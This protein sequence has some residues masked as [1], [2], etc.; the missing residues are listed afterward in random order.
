MSEYKLTPQSQIDDY[1]LKMAVSLKHGN[2]VEFC[3]LENRLWRW[4]YSM[5]IRRSPDRIQEEADAIIKKISG[6]DAGFSAE[7]KLFRQDDK[8]FG[9]CLDCGYKSWQGEFFYDDGTFA[10]CPDC[11]S[12]RMH[13][14]Y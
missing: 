10:G 7:Y 11:E 14:V 8:P 1:I 3:R 6:L 13:E 4:F 5:H 2:L 9:Y 12:K